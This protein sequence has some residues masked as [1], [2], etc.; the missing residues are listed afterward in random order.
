M[1]NIPDSLPPITIALS[2]FVAIDRMLDTQ[3]IN[4]A[5]QQ[6]IAKYLERELERAAVV[7]S[8]DLPK[9]VVSMY[10]KVTYADSKSGGSHSV[11]LVYP[12]EADIRVNK[13]SLMTPIGAALIGM[14][15]GNSIT[16]Y[17]PDGGEHTI[18][19]LAVNQPTR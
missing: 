8:K 12:H 5:P 13:V 16:W 10:S 15:T 14:A 1:F 17:T 7:P 3:S 9:H 2:D 6:K 4:E 18:T 11:Q 19:I